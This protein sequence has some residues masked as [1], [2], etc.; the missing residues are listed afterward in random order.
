MAHLIG[1][2]PD[3][4]EVKRCSDDG[5]TQVESDKAEI[6]RRLD[7]VG[8]HDTKGTL[9]AQKTLLQEGRFTIVHLLAAVL[10]AFILGILLF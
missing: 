9:Q 8:L 4:K 5:D 3:D 7:A 6:K 2:H 1:D 10:V